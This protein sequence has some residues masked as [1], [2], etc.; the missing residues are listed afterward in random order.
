MVIPFAQSTQTFVLR[1]E[2]YTYAFRICEGKPLHVYYSPAVGYADLSP[3]RGMRL[4]AFLLMISDEPSALRFC[5]LPLEFSEF[6]RDDFRT[7]TLILAG[8][9]FAST[10]YRYVGYAV[11]DRHPDTGRVYG[12][13]LVYSGSFEISA[14]VDQQRNTRVVAGYNPET[15]V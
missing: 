7:P 5:D 1:G 11:T 12:V 13:S 2:T 6:G 15:F 10:D 14:K 3:L 8:D 9:G 4:M